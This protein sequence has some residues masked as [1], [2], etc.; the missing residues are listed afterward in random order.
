MNDYSLPL[1]TLR[2]LAK[3]YE[4]AMLKRQYDKAYELANDI[5]EMALKLQDL[6]DD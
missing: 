6:A 3:D 1:L 2:R 4:A 5:V